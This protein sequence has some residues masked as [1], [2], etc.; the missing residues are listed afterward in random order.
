MPKAT[1]RYDVNGPKGTIDVFES[2]FKP[3]TLGSGGFGTF[4]DPLLPRDLRLVPF[5]V[6]NING[7]LYV[8]YAPA[9]RAAQISATPGQGA[10]AIFDTN[11]NFIRQLVVGSQLASPWGRRPSASSSAT[12]LSATSPSASARSTPS[13]PRPAS[14]LARS[15]M[16]RAIRYSIPGCGH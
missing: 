1:S 7:Q 4:S 3:V 9:G 2:S 12:C 11:G 5:N 10:V 8:T 13:I 15:P 14:S 16:P 6:Q